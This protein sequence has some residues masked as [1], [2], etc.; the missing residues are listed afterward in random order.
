MGNDN[1]PLDVITLGRAGVDLYG[2]QVGGRL[3]DMLS[4]AKYVG[5]CPANIAIGSSRLGLR[6]GII[7]RVGNDHMGRFIVEQMEREGVSTAG[8]IRDSERLTALVILGIRDRES[9]PLIFY[10][11]NC[12][13]AALCEA[14]IDPDFV[15]SSRSLLITGTHLST[16]ALKAASMKA[17]ALMKAAGGRIM[18]DI[19]YRPVLWGLTSPEL[20]EERFVPDENV[21]RS[22]QTVVGD[23][24]LIV[25]TEEELH[26]LGG[27]TDTLEAIRRVR[28]LS[29]ATIVCKRG[30]QGCVAFDGPIPD[31]IE[32][33]VSGEGFQIEVF[34]VLGAG[35][36]FMSGFLCGWL[37]DKPLEECCR[38]A[39]ASGA[40]VV[41]RHGCAPAI[42]TLNELD[43]FLSGKVRT[44][45][46]RKDAAL[47]QLHWSETRRALDGDVM[48]LAIDHRKQ[49]EDIAAETGAD[50][51]RIQQIKRLALEAVHA[52]GEAQPG[53]GILVDSRYGEEALQQAADFPYW[54]GRPIELPGSRPLEFETGLDI[55]SELK[56]WPAGQ[57]V[58]CLCFYHPD[59]PEELKARQERQIARLFSACRNTGHELLLEIIA[60]PHGAVDAHTV[61]KV[62]RRIYALGIYPDWWKLEPSMDRVAWHN[63]ETAINEHDPH[64]RGVL[65]LGLSAPEEVLIECFQV[66]V[67]VPVIRGFAVGRTIFAEPARRWLAGEL[68]D[69][70]AVTM[71][72]NNFSKLVTA[73]NQARNAGRQ[74]PGRG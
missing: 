46:L 23:C 5:G 60:S 32:A 71:L 16:P 4:F 41:S 31:D 25:G 10:R 51:A 27:S 14:D 48:I 26:I 65:L 6:S 24:D 69:S 55:G 59:D 12:A 29:A 67:Q 7:T 63:V 37:R 19:D 3:E 70:G 15:A 35:D 61:E 57:V 47:E 40:I 30:E 49:I 18:L 58:K 44:R 50:P 1:T 42:P 36:A 74:S 17:V 9:F 53:L 34:N 8:V 2:Q 66:A 33:G 21:T 64:C 38:L 11:E 39:N 72:K 20:G 28:A 52:L 45:V 13:D 68:D 54:I 73:W 56:E 43:Y 62:I 22:L